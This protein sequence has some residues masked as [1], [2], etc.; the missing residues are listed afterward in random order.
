[1]NM[2]SVGD[3]IARARAAKGMN[4]SDLARALKVTPQAVQKWEAGGS[5]PKGARLRHVA[6][7]LGT[8]IEH[9]LTGDAGADAVGAPEVMTVRD[10]EFMRRLNDLPGECRRTLEIV[11]AEQERLIGR[12]QV[13]AVEH[14]LRQIHGR[15]DTGASR[16]IPFTMSESLLD[17]DESQ[18]HINRHKKR[19][20]R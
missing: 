4:Q 19:T 6:S 2:E 14:L 11:L 8:T 1:M 13:S 5:L 18:N 10:L 12:V 17:D 9:L 16:D 3:R 20:S 7:A 15:Q